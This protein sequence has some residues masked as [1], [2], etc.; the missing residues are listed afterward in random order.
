[1]PSKILIFCATAISPFTCLGFS[2]L[3]FLNSP[4]LRKL[5]LDLNAREL[6][7]LSG[8]HAFGPGCHAANAFLQIHAR[9]CAKHTV[10]FAMIRIG[11]LHLIARLQVVDRWRYAKLL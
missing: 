2:G 7:A 5:F 4:A 9:W 11:M 10:R 6:L 3:W 1:M 8:T